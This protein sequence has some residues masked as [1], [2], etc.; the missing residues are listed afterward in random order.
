MAYLFFSASAWYGIPTNAA[1]C[2]ATLLGDRGGRSYK[3]AA[4]PLRT[5]AGMGV[6]LFLGNLIIFNRK[7]LFDRKRPLTSRKKY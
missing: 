4:G 1:T 5:G 6:G 3:A 2:L 7:I